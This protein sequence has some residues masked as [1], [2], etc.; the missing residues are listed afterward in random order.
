M[1]EGGGAFLGFPEAILEKNK[2]RGKKVCF[3]SS[4]WD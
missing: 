1:H 2:K 3:L 4:V